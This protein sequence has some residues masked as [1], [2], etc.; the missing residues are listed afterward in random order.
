MGKVAK[1]TFSNDGLSL[2]GFI[3]EGSDGNREFVNAFVEF[4]SLDAATAGW[5]REGMNTLMQEGRTAVISTKGCGA[6]GRVTTLDSVRAVV[7]SKPDGAGIYSVQVSSQL[8][9]DDARASFRALQNQYPLVLGSH[10]PLIR[11]ADLGENRILSCGSW[12][13]R[14]SRSGLATLRQPERCRGPMHRSKELCPSSIRNLLANQT[15][16]IPRVRKTHGNLSYSWCT[17]CSITASAESS[18]LLAP[19]FPHVPIGI[20]TLQKTYPRPVHW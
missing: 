16:A 14:N 4:G 18:Q 9:E 3:I 5:I 19:H 2:T 6:A 7:P 1:R 20:R 12:P 15:S 11:R 10:L 17:A 8:S 13:I